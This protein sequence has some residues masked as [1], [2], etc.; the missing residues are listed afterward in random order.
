MVGDTAPVV[1]ASIMGLVAYYILMSGRSTRGIMILAFTLVLM[2]IY[3]P[4]S[5][6]YDV[7]LHLSFLAVLGIMYFQEFF[8]RVFSWVPGALAIRE[9][10]VLTFS[11]MILT[12]PIMIFNF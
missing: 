7:S 10:L 3:S 12:L 2:L 11:A 8:S 4:M 9:S 5:I 1:R 6:R